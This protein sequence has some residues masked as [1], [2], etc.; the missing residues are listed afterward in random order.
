MLTFAALEQAVNLAELI[1]VFDLFIRDLGLDTFQLS[2]I[3]DIDDFP[4][5]NLSIGTLSSSYIKQ[6]WQDGNNVFHD[7]VARNVLSSNQPIRFGHVSLSDKVSVREKK[8]LELRKKH[9]IID[10]YGFPLKGRLNRFAVVVIHGDVGGLRSAD[11][12]LIEMACI[13]LYRQA[14]ELFPLQP[15]LVISEPALLTDRERECLSWAAKGKTNWDISQI[16]LIT[17]RT[18][19]YHVENAR[20]KLGAESRLQAVVIAARQL[21]IVL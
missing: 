10:G 4:G 12:A 16:L 8:N 5:A 9:G 3:T 15:Y 14:T 7:P 11:L 13:K 19:Q 17:E 20:E 1:K 18:V 2:E 21:E 6:Y